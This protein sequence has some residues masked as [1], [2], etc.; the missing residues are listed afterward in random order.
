[1]PGSNRST[2]KPWT[3]LQ[4]CQRGQRPV[5]ASPG[6]GRLDDPQFLG[7]Q[8]APEVGGDVRR[9]G[10]LGRLP[11]AVAAVAE[12][13]GR[14][15]AGQG[16]G[17]ERPPCVAGVTAQR[18]PL[19]GTQHGGI[20]HAARPQLRTSPGW[21]RRAA[22]S[23]PRSGQIAGGGDMRSSLH[24][25]V[26]LR[27]CHRNRFPILDPTL[28]PS[29][30]PTRSCVD[31]S[32]VAIISWGSPLNLA[33]PPSAAGL[34]Q[35]QDR[36]HSPPRR[37]G[38]I[39]LTES[40]SPPRLHLDAATTGST[41][42]QTL[43]ISQ[44]GRVL[45]LD[46]GGGG[47]ARTARGWR[48]PRGLTSRRDLRSEDLIPIDSNHDTRRNHDLRHE[49]HDARRGPMDDGWALLRVQQGRQPDRRRADQQGPAGRLP[50]PPP[51]GGADPDHP[52]RPERTN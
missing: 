51:R 8:D 38:D 50:A 35:G 45:A 2:K 30:F 9:G 39:V 46:R 34:T 17:L 10:L 28:V 4:A 7:G 18:L 19:A 24:R 12:A 32:E 5:E 37:S 40:A 42:S 21:P 27:G 36:R 52:L 49:R 1:M 16:H 41:S 47:T 13:V 31:P 48:R 20:G 33:R 15:P 6:L 11:C 22:G 26:S 43:L 25:M 14:Q 44:H 23:E 29:S 3:P